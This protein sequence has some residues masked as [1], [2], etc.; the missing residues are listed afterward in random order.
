MTSSSSPATGFSRSPG[1][2]TGSFSAPV[3]E[4]AGVSFSYDRDNVLDNVSLTVAPEEFLALIGPNGG[5]K[6]TLLRLILGLLQPDTG[7]VRVFGAAPGAMN[8]RIGYVPQFCTMQAAFPAS[9]LDMVLMGAARPSPRGG[10]WATGRAARKKA[11]QYLD[12]LGLADCARHPIGALSGG[13]RQRVLVARAL[14]SRPESENGPSP[15]LLLLDEPTAS[16]DPEGTFCFY[17]F[18][19]KLRGSVSLLVVS[20]DL[21]MV[22]PFFSS[23]A[24]VNKNLTRLRDG[25]L[26]PDNLTALFGRHLHECPV[27]D[28]QHAGRALHDSGC[29]HHACT[30]A[31]AGLGRD[32]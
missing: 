12:T 22:S 16:I 30:D 28:L 32:F 3:V 14:M 1:S 24:V 15:F 19:D 9:V 2:Q 13:Q 6:T 5:G 18:M 17:E 10:N 29:T 27:A 20:H 21:L 4:I 31:G 23:I 11:V 7:N 25:E 8:N 26:T